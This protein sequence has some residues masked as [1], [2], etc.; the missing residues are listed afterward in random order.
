MELN[1]ENVDV[2]DS[3]FAEDNSIYGIYITNNGR[4]TNTPIIVFDNS[5][6]YKDKIRTLT[7]EELLL[8]IQ[9]LKTEINS[10]H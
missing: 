3:D 4:Y 10:N 7:S 8:I 9:I 6:V 1:T 2:F 5:L